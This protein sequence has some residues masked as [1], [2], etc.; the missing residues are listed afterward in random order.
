[1]PACFPP[2]PRA[3]LGIAAVSLSL[4]AQAASWPEE[5]P[6]QLIL[7]ASA[8]SQPDILGRLLAQRLSADLGQSIVI[9]NKAGATG[10]VGNDAVVRAKPDG[11]TLGFTYA[12]TII[13]NKLLNP[14]MPHD[15]LTDLTPIAQVGRGGNLLV[16]TQDFPAK[17][18]P[19]VVAEVKNNPGKYNYASWGTGS[20]GHIAMESIKHQTGMDIEHIPYKTVPQILTDLKGGRIQ[21][22]FVDASGPLPM[23]QSGELIPV[24]SSASVR[25]PATPQVPTLLEQGVQFNADAWFGLFGP[26]GMDPALVERI[27]AAMNKAMVDPEIAARFEQLNMAAP[28]PR[29]SAEFAAT[30]ANDVKVWDEVIK[31]AHI[32]LP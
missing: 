28:Q 4:A 14:S 16:V 20:G 7:P 10:V 11:Y 27:N 25:P 3:L 1:M 26:K 32:S 17:D 8:G 30:I 21:V 12:A 6:I 9:E 15:P 29:T 13:G 23:I 22:A 5:R 2:W 31:A 18:F 24:V 19:G